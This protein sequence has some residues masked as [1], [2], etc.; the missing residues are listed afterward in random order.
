MSLIKK[1]LLLCRPA[2]RSTLRS[3]PV[4]PAG[5]GWRDGVAVSVGHGSRQLVG[6]LTRLVKAGAVAVSARL[7]IVGLVSRIAASSGAESGCGAQS[8]LLVSRLLVRR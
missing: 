6:V 2:G 5:A 4:R 3:V 8:R 7:V 1:T